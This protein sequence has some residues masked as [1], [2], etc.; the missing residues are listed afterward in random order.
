MVFNEPCKSKVNN[1]RLC[2][3]ATGQLVKK[4]TRTSQG[5]KSSHIF[6]YAAILHNGLF[7]T[8]VSQMLSETQDM[9]T[10]PYWL[11]Q[12][13]RSGA[14]LP[15]EI[16]CSYSYALIGAIT[17]SY[18]Q[19]SRSRYYDICLRVLQ[20][21]ET[22]SPA[23]CIRLGI[24][25]FIKMICHWKCLGKS[26]I[27]EFFVRSLIILVESETLE[28]FEEIFVKIVVIA[29]SETDG[30]ELRSTSVPVPA[31]L[32]RSHMISMIKDTNLLNDFELD[33]EDL[34][35]ITNH[36][37]NEDNY[38]SNQNNMDVYLTYLIEQIDN[39]CSVEGNRLNAYYI[40]E[41]KINLMRIVK[42]FLMW[43]NVMNNYFKSNCLT[44]T[45]APV[46]GYIGKL[47]SKFSKLLTADRFVTSHL[48]T[49]ES[50]T[51]ISKSIQIENRDQDIAT[52]KYE[53]L[54]TNREDV[55]FKDALTENNELNNDRTE[56]HLFKNKIPNYNGYEDDFAHYNISKDNEI[57]KAI[58][59]D[60]NEGNIFLDNLQYETDI[61][62]LL[63]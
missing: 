61:K 46:E 47:K 16:V 39:Y 42:D 55:R 28:K 11:N 38:S 1:C 2:I 12:W 37:L 53:L 36:D 30:L 17:F 20:N 29:S 58:C 27:K 49:I 22:T 48:K 35:T 5:L 41:L 40:P 62:D 32:F 13:I 21:N 63:K 60:P 33:N 52:N 15:H 56:K 43:S 26:R 8:P 10:I 59:D 23:V 7:Q 44:A 3:D 57:V 19:M 6:L 34:N 4:I 31:E 45:G 50:E 51:K 24:A 18:C 9:S 25:H 54:N 14:K